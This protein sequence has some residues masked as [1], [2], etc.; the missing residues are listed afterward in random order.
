MSNPVVEMSAV[1]LS[2]AIH[3][4]KVSCC[5]VMSSYLDHIDRTNPRVNA[6]VTRVDRDT[7]M[8]QAGEKD[9]ELAAGRDNGWMHGF[10]QAVKDLVPTKGIRTTK[11]SLA[12]KDWVP[13]ADGAVVKSMKRD[14]AII[15]GKTNTPEFG[16]GSQTYNEV[17]G[18]TGNPYDESKTCGGSSGGAAC[19]VA[20]R[21]QAVADGGDFMGSLRNPAGWCNVIGFRA[22]LGTVASGG[23]D[24]FTN[25]MSMNG[26]MGR[27]V[28][29]VA[30]LLAT[31]A[32]YNPAFPLTHEEDPRLKALTPDN[33]HEA[34]RSKSQKGVR[35]AWIGDWDGA[36]PME[37]GVMATCEKALAHVK[38]FGASV[39]P[40]KP[41]YNLNEFWETIW[42]P[43]RHYCAASLK[44]WY[45]KCKQSLLKPE[46]RWEYEGSLTMGA[47]EVYRAF[48]KRTEFY[49]AM[50]KVYENYDYIVSPTAV[51]FPFDKN[52]H[53]PETVA[54]RPMHT[55]HNWMEIVTPWTMGGNAVIAMPAGFGGAHNLSMGIQIIAAPRKEYE[56]LQF[57]A[58]YEAATNFTAKF[59]PKY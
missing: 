8:K 2:K 44:P 7:L 14:G 18:A 42:L 4:K 29:D 3:A 43:I 50:L 24:L 27:S 32:G 33:V 40:I 51:C 47:Q 23:T 57:A 58:A 1:E 15:I 16:Y 13:A 45:D 52:M 34:L 20:L 6:I 53:W 48:E 31:L 39:E 46:S 38:D 56:L 21:M 30:L 25:S 26:P 54:G 22:S 59:P 36:L 55:Y 5:E 28:D 11:G 41:F 17:F 37:D 35:V 19:S 49:H 9:A 10:P 12:L